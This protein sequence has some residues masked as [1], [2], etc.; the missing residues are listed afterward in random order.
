ML[1]SAGGGLHRFLVGD[2]KK[3]WLTIIKIGCSMLGVRSE[4]KAYHFLCFTFFFIFVKL[5]YVKQLKRPV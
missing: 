2:I 5:A 1:L 4:V 3:N